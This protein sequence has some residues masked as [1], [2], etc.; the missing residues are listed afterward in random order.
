MQ[1]PHWELLSFSAESWSQYGLCLN[2]DGGA[3]A[4]GSL[5]FY[6]GGCHVCV[7]WV[8]D[9][10]EDGTTGGGCGAVKELISEFTASTLAILDTE[11]ELR[12]YLGA[13]G[14]GRGGDPI[15]NTIGLVTSYARA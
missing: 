9:G 4:H 15:L 1:R 8:R 10:P 3:A 2:I 13:Y 11:A 7:H 5:D 14:I 12:Q 6:V